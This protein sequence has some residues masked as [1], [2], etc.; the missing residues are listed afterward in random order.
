MSRAH[1]AGAEGLF[2]DAPERVPVRTVLELA[3]RQHLSIAR[4]HS[5]AV[6]LYAHRC[7]GADDASGI[8]LCAANYRSQTVTA[9]AT[10]ELVTVVHHGSYEWSRRSS[11]RL[12]RVAKLS[13][14]TSV[15]RSKFP[16]FWVGFNQLLGIFPL[17]LLGQA[18]GGIDLAIAA[19]VVGL[20]AR[21]PYRVAQLSGRL[22][23]LVRAVGPD[24][25]VFRESRQWTYA[26]TMA[27]I[28]ELFPILV[29]VLG[30]GLL[31]SDKPV[32]LTVLSIYS[33]TPLG[34][35]AVFSAIL[36]L[37]LGQYFP[38]FPDA[39]QALRVSGQFVSLAAICLAWLIF[40]VPNSL[41]FVSVLPLI[42]MFALLLTTAIGSG[43]VASLMLAALSSTIFLVIFASLT[44]K[45]GRRPD[46][47]PESS[48]GVI[49]EEDE[50]W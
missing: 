11:L 28:A 8:A 47:S 38:E 1:R 42:S 9:E 30:A 19:I 44:F 33:L 37:R 50:L 13:L 12:L 17:A 49:A 45:V 25:R 41:L 36:Y 32:S 5:L 18:L 6:D 43:S 48:H 7:P 21:L 26:A 4:A 23:G 20:V 2:Q 34:L 40:T 14:R 27:S 15:G 29:I 16:W 46:P 24:K 35:T 3:R 10:P 39:R 31:L 22:E